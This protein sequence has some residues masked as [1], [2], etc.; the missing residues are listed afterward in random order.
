M[1]AGIAVTAALLL[2]LRSDLG[3]LHWV[4][5]AM[6]GL[7][8]VTSGTLAVVCRGRRRHQLGLSVIVVVMCITSLVAVAHVGTFSGAVVVLCL[9]IFAFT[10]GRS[11]ARA[12]TTY[13]LCAGGHAM[14]VGLTC[15][16][17]LECSVFGAALSMAEPIGFAVALQIVYALTFWFALHSRVAN[18]HALQRVE[19]ICG[20]LVAQEALLDEA[21]AEVDRI[22]A[23][24]RVGRMTG[25]RVGA[26]RAREVI[27]RGGMGEIYSAWDIDRGRSVALKV[28]HE[29]LRDHPEVVDRFFLEVRISRSL[30][31]PHLVDVLDAGLTE[32]GRP[33]L[34]MELLDGMDL[35]RMLRD[36]KTL[37]IRLA[38]DLV[39]QVADA[40]DTAHRAGIVH[41][42]IKPQNVFWVKGPGMWKVLDF[43]VSKLRDSNAGL[44]KQGMLLGTPQYMSPEQALGVEVDPRT[45]VFGLGAIAYRV[46]TGRPPFTGPDACSTVYQVVHEQPIAPFHDHRLH[47]DVELVLAIALAKVPADR[48]VSTRALADA[49]K[50]AARGQLDPRTRARG[51]A[52]L[53]ADPWSEGLRRRSGV[54]RRTV[55]S[56]S[57]LT[58]PLLAAAGKPWHAA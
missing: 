41:R 25:K 2:Q 52:H 3:V 10:V 48:F 32:D 33:Y 1:G 24:G 58:S 21:H 34:A 6:L 56:D 12:W 55:G 30:T 43:G 23:A 28:L 38:I 57:A 18:E 46:L 27:G 15:A 5:T 16:G 54:R 40:L 7:T 19:S 47:P 36:E 29:S 39:T 8:A 31:S 53:D 13:V 11:R 42:D 9:L 14:L 44:T 50:A 45:D 37:P 20:E 26:Y 35:S 51:R 17:V 4:T 22:V 49:M